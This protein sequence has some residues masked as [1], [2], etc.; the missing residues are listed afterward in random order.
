MSHPIF[1]SIDFDF[2]PVM[3]A[4]ADRLQTNRGET[5][6]AMVFDWGQAETGTIATIQDFLWHER[7]ASFRRLGLDLEQMFSIDP[8][9]GS[10]S[11]DE[12]LATVPSAGMTPWYPSHVQA[13]PMLRFV[14]DQDGPVEVWHF[15]AH[16]DLGYGA[17]RVAA[18]RESGNITCE[19]W[20]LAALDLGHAEAVHIVYPD[21]R[22]RLEWEDVSK[23]PWLDGLAVHVHTWSEVREQVKALPAPAAQFLARSD[24]WSPPYLDSEFV[25]LAEGLGFVLQQPSEPELPLIR[26]WSAE[27]IDEAE[28]L[29]RR[30]EEMMAEQ[31]RQR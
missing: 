31:Q 27:R 13:F 30:A 25:R 26:E 28:E 21:W 11:V 6:A 22:G 3:P 1:L 14:A 15:D 29:Q 18:M 4:P 9:R 7:A 19:D 2:F 12:F 16:H 8:E 24:S 10:T 20:L 23:R 17:D 5:V